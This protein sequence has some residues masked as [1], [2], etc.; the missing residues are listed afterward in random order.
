MHK[1]TEQ[2]VGASKLKLPPY[3]RKVVF[4]V[5]V[6][7]RSARVRRPA[8]C[9]RA[10]RQATGGGFLQAKGAL[11]VAGLRETQRECDIH[12]GVSISY[13]ETNS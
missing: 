5:G 8:A 10:Q 11:L 9:Q 6:W 4:A 12:F 3:L 1:T 7:Q 13:I 2:L